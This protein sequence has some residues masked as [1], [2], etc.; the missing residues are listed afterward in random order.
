MANE[1]RGY[2]S[3]SVRIVAKTEHVARAVQNTRNTIIKRA[4]Y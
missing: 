1:L 3:I 2:F 4:Q